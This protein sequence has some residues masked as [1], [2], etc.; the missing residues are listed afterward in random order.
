LPDHKNPGAKRQE[1]NCPG[2]SKIDNKW[3]KRAEEMIEIMRSNDPIGLSYAESLLKDR[4]IACFIADQ[5]MS[6]LEGSL[7]VL[8]RRLMVDTER[9]DEARM[10][11]RDAGLGGEL[12]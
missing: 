2:R 1:A 8:Q 5:G 9:A 12:K 3:Q 4:G 10:T 7:G 6:V 11:L